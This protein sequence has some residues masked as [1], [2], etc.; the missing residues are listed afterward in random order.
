MSV[1]RTIDSHQHFWRLGRGDYHWLTDELKAIYRDFL[2]ETLAPL[3]AASGIDKSI[4]VQAAETVNESDFILELAEDNEFVSGV[5]AWVNM[6]DSTD[7]AALERWKDNPY[8][9]GIRPVMQD[10]PDLEWMLK[11]ELDWAFQWLMQNDFSFDALVKPPQL[12]NL[13]KLAD[14]YEQQRMVIDHGAKPYI[15]EGEMEPWA[16]HMAALAER[17]HVYCKLSGLVTEAG[18]D[19][20]YEKLEPYMEHLL[21]CFGA[22]RLMWGSDWPVC[23]LASTY[24]TW[25]DISR[26]F[27]G[28]LSES[29]QALIWGDTAHAFYKIKCD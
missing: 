27:L 21:A 18:E 13:L 28:A 9:L 20:S 17:P 11:P 23:T 26:R 16:S 5:V 24:D 22:E 6:E 4:T 25:V 12:Q 2:P 14:R 3:L 1:N 7:L 29:E 15:A 8:F 10:I 19:V